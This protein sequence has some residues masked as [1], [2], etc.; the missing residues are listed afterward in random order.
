MKIKVKRWVSYDEANK[1]PVACGGMGGWVNK[2]TTW[3]NYITSLPGSQRK[4]IEALKDEILEKDI[5]ITGGEHQHGGE[6]VPIFSD[7]TQ[8]AF[9]YRAWGDLMA[10]IWNSFRKVDQIDGKGYMDYYM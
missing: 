6:G 3:E 10:A 1:L 9:T 7:D 5:H 4:Y 8:A 2:D